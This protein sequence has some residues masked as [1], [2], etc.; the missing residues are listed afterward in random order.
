MSEG[1]TVSIITP[2][3]NGEKYLD[4]Y[5]NSILNQTYPAIEL[6]FV[7]DGSNDR[8]EDIALAYGKQLE[9]RGYKFIYVYQDNAGQSAAI[10]QGLKLFTGDYLTWPDSDDYL[11]ENS[12]EV[13]VNCLEKYPEAGMV[14][15]TT[16]N[17]DDESL[18]E[19]S[20]VGMPKSQKPEYVFN[21]VFDI[22]FC[23][24]PVSMMVRSSYFRKTMPNPLK[25]QTPRLIGQNYQL[26]IPLIY[27]YPICYL[28]DI[29]GYYRFHRDSHSHSRTSFEKKQNIIDCGRDVLNN[30]ADDIEKD[31]EKNQALKVFIERRV[32]NERLDA[33][34][35]YNRRDNLKEYV[36]RMKTIG[37]FDSYAR[38]KVLKIKYPIVKRIADKIWRFRKRQ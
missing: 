15:G 1:K 24:T 21:K 29:T 16:V 27:S 14:I 20:V 37:A 17:F 36:S 23:W 3:Y 30:I 33:L 4:Q 12:I 13:R 35:H 31:T 18:R 7:N 5:F 32:L 9:E 26:V 10:N 2:C 11:S 38:R 22:D 19:V 8:T 6:I 25:I 28:E 34:A